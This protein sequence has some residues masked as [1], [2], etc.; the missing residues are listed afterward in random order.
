MAQQAASDSL[1]LLSNLF[2]CLT[3]DGAKLFFYSWVLSKRNLTE[4]ESVISCLIKASDLNYSSLQICFVSHFGWR[5]LV[6]NHAAPAKVHLYNIYTCMYVLSKKTCHF[7]LR[8]LYC[9]CA[10]TCV[11]CVWMWTCAPCECVLMW[12]HGNAR[13]SA[14][15]GIC[16]FGHCIQREDDHKTTRGSNGA[17]ITD[18]GPL[19]VYLQKKSKE[20]DIE[21]I[22]MNL[23]CSLS[24]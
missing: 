13:I 19:G 11:C 20:Y 14:C 1:R 5:K 17:S 23:I 10:C 9:A 24:M 22:W 4:S 6:Q 21:K 12:L 16:G 2:H 3:S 18:R 7:L 8:S 15:L